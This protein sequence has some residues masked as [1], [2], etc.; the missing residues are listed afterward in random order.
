M[1]DTNTARNADGRRV[2][3]RPGTGRRWGSGGRTVRRPAAGE[4]GSRASGREVAGEACGPFDAGRLTRPAGTS[5]SAL[6]AAA[7]SQVDPVS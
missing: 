7:V 6:A 1:E 2:V 5:W 4:E 3:G